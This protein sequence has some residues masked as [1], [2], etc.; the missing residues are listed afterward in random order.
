MKKN[1]SN[2]YSYAESTRFACVRLLEQT[3]QHWGQN[4]PVLLKEDKV[5]SKQS[6]SVALRVA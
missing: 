2:Q 1:T 6:K 3:I 4:V 5:L